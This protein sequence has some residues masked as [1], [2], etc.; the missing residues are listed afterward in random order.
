MT[1]CNTAPAAARALLGW[2]RADLANAAGLHANSVRYWE[3]MSVI[4]TG[5]HREPV[6]CR[7]MRAALSAAGVTIMGGNKTGVGMDKVT[8]KST[9]TRERA[10][11]S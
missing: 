1:L 5:G 2:S 7:H 6:A 10:R 4:P 11:A 9:S 8:N 3:A